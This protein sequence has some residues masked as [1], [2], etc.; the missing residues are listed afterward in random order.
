VLYGL[1]APDQLRNRGHVN[2]PKITA[3]LKEQRRT[4]DREARK[5][6]I[7]DL[8]RYITEQQYYVYLYCAGFT[9]SWYPY[10]KNYA[11]NTTYDYGGRSAALWLDR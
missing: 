7:F 4:K 2:D 11:P 10:V 1:Y 3:M 6:V 8:Q 9:G 5:Q